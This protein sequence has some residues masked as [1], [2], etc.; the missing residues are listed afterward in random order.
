MKINVQTK[1]S[2]N[3]KKKIDKNRKE[4]LEKKYLQCLL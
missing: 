2:Y 1:C 3:T 4:E